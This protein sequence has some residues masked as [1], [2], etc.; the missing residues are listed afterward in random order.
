MKMNEDESFILC[1][2]AVKETTPELGDKEYY[3]DKRNRL[4]LFVSISRQA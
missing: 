2:P 1:S 4:E 3:V